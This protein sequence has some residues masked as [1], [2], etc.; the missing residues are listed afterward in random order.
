MQSKNLM[1]AVREEVLHHYGTNDQRG[2]EST[3]GHY[4]ITA[5][6]AVGKNPLWTSNAC[7]VIY[8]LPLHFSLL[9]L[10]H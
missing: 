3:V 7:P 8:F 6:E 10:F 1:L 2:E 5:P 9:P 4:S